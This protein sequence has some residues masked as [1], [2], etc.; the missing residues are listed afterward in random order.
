MIDM[1]R[2]NFNQLLTDSKI[3]IVDCWAPWCAACRDFQPVYENI[4][5]KYPRYTFAKLDTAQEKEVT[6]KLGVVNIPTLIIFRD[7]IMIF[8]QPG[9]MEPGGLDDVIRQAENI[10][11]DQV[12]AHIEAKENPE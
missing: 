10:D 9:Y 4:A 5:Q 3:L 6:K 7:E 1:T 12:R 2:E 11:M 8:M